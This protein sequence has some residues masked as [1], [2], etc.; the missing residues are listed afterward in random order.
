V[1]GK[2]AER[3]VLGEDRPGRLHP[4]APE[5]ATGADHEVEQR[6]RL[7]RSGRHE[8]QEAGVIDRDAGGRQ[9]VAEDAQRLQPADACGRHGVAGHRPQLF[10][11]AGV[12]QRW[13]VHPQALDR[14]A[15]DRLDQDLVVGV[16]AMHAGQDATPRPCLSG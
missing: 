12:V 8:R 6:R 5:H 15:D 2:P 9:H 4:G 11:G 7:G 14:V 13:R 1:A 3:L 16:Q 10:L